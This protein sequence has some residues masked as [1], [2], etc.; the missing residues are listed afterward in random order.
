MDPLIEKLS[1]PI[2]DHFEGWKLGMR[3]WDKTYRHHKV[4]MWFAKLARR[5]LKRKG[6]RELYV[7]WFGDHLPSSIFDHWGRFRIGDEWFVMSQ[8]YSG[9]PARAQAFADEIGCD[10]VHGPHRGPWNQGTSMF[11]FR[12]RKETIS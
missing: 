6:C 2:P 4:P 7:T 11:V 1:I 8:P 12:Q 10:F 9:D 3:A 5:W